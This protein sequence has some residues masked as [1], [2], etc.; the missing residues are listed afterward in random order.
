MGV[1]THPRWKYAQSIR[2]WFCCKKLKFPIGNLIYKMKCSKIVYF[3]IESLSNVPE[4][5]PFNEHRK[6]PT[7]V[8]LAIYTMCIF[9][10]LWWQIAIANQNISTQMNFSHQSNVLWVFRNFVKRWM[11]YFF[12]KNVEIQTKDSMK[13]VKHH[14][15]CLVWQV[16]FIFFG[17]HKFV[18]WI[19]T[20]C[21]EFC[22]L[23]DG[24]KWIIKSI[25]PWVKWIFLI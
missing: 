2:E 10:S 16:F 9:A 6:H 8:T 5:F 22:Q 17:Q 7:R 15:K 24:K 11:K 1:E 21:L 14:P 19:E 13:N 25:L 20:K 12:T 23:H 4:S 3:M 18:E